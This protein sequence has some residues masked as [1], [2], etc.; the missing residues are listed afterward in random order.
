MKTL[1]MLI[2]LTLCA[3]A[4]R[5]EGAYADQHGASAFRLAHGKYFRT[6][7]DGSDFKTVRQGQ[8]PLPIPHPYKLDGNMVVV[9]QGSN[10]AEFE[11]LPDGRLKLSEGGQ[12]L[13]FVRK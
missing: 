2:S 12:A 11:I 5:V 10:R 3:C 1:A 6:N 13:I 9:E 4:P 8:P 7:P